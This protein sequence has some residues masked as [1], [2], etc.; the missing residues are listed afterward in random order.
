MPTD[1]AIVAARPEVR[2]DGTTIDDLTNG[3]E[4]MRIHEGRET[5]ADARARGR[6]LG[7]AGGGRHARLPLPRP[8]AA[9]LRQADRGRLR[10]D[11]RSSRPDHGPRGRVPAQRRPRARRARRGRAAG[12][13]ADAAHA[14]VRERQRRGRRAHGGERPQPHAAGRPARPDAPRASPSSTSPTSRS[15]ATASA[16]VGGELW[17]RDGELHAAPAHRRAAGSGSTPKLRLNQEISE[18]RVRA[19]LAH[20]ATEV[21]VGGWDVAAAAAIAERAGDCG[22]RR[23]VAG[24]RDRRDDPAAGVRRRASRP[25][26][27]PRPAGT[28]R[29]A[30]PRRRDLPRARPPLRARRGGVRHSSGELSVGSSFTLEGAGA[31][32]SG[33]YQVIDVVHRFDADRGRAQRADVRAR[34]AEGV[35]AMSSPTAYELLRAPTGAGDGRWYGVHVALVIDVKD[36]DGQARVKIELP[37]SPD[38]DGAPWEAWARLAT[39]MAGDDRGTLLRARRRRRGAR[40]L[41]GRRPAPPVRGRRPVERQ[42]QAAGVDGRRRQERHQG[43]LLAHRRE[44]HARRHERHASACSSRRPAARRSCSRDGPSKLLAQD[45]NGNSVELS[46]SGITVTVVGQGHG[47]RLDRRDQ[48]R[49]GDRQR[50][51]LDLQRRREVRHADHQQR[52]QLLVHA[53]RGEHLVSVAAPPIPCAGRRPA[54]LW[55]DARRWRRRCSCGSPATASWT[56]CARCSRATPTRSPRCARRRARTACARPDG[57]PAG[58]RPGRRRGR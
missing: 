10:L 9:R 43:D 14:H 30:G 18:L 46:S 8:P 11:A 54:P 50:R 37:W 4:V 15:C 36:P 39:L 1:Q 17:V 33:D 19:D 26:P 27:P 7:H 49:L 20:Q 44:G 42:G 22:A 24:R 57:R 32:F 16:R 3:L 41:P 12:A 51:H 45:A 35:R 48:R 21:V 53:G 38:P 55:G 13:A 25:S 58:S 6:Q 52:R 47:Q 31:P 23:R 28:R 40:R 56:T 2:V 34:G 29:G 5:P